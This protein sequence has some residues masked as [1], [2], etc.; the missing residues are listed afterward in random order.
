MNEIKVTHP[1]AGEQTFYCKAKTVEQMKKEIRFTYGKMLDNCTI[2][3]INDKGI[4]FS[5]KDKVEDL[6]YLSVGE[7]VRKTGWTIS[8]IKRDY[9]GNKTRFERL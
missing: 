8:T 1:T 4:R 6:I 9:G 5:I 2:E 7:A 3:V